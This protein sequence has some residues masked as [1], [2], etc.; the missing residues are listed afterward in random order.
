MAKAL[1]MEY[2]HFAKKPSRKGFMKARE[3]LNLPSE[4]IA[5]VGDQIFTDVIGANRSNMFAILVKPISKKDLLITK[6][7]RPL[8]EW[9]V[10]KYLKSLEKTKEG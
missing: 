4:N 3:K 7:K 2:I 1:N 6:W 8:E 9:I 10:K 5:V